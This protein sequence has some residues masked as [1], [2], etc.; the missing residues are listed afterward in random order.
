MTA[1]TPE[2]S[3]DNSVYILI[4]Q[5]LQN[6]FFLAE[7]GRLC[8]PPKMVAHMLIGGSEKDEEVADNVWPETEKNEEGIRR[9]VKESKL[10]EGPLYRFLNT[11]LNDKQRTNTLHIITIKDWHIASE[12]YDRERRTYGPHCEAG[13]WQAQVIDGFEKLLEPHGLN[14]VPSSVTLP[15][16]P[17]ALEDCRV[18]RNVYYE[19][20]SDTLFDFLPEPAKGN[21]S[22]QP[23]RLTRILDHIM[24]GGKKRAYVVVTGVYT[25][26][27]IQTL[28]TGL[29]SRYHLHN[30]IVS[31]VLTA[32]PTLERHLAGLDFAHK[33]L[34]VEIVHSL[35][36][37]I[38]VLHP[39]FEGKIDPE[40]TRLQPDFFKYK[41]YFL[42]K[43]YV[44]SYQDAKLSDYLDLTSHRSTAQYKLTMRVA[45]MLL[46]FGIIFLGIS[47]LA[48]ARYVIQPNQYSDEIIGVFGFTM[49]TNLVTIFFWRTLQNTQRSMLAQV[50]LRNY[51]ETYSTITGLVRHHFTAPEFL[52]DPMRVTEPDKV[53]RRIDRQIEIIG[54]AADAMSD[55]FRDLTFRDDAATES[56]D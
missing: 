23:S 27:K 4:T 5:C 3:G 38:R 43:Q 41:T 47:A 22:P 11:L 21:G 26:I 25:D 48:A 15:S 54:K 6:S 28:L 24:E 50:R 55:N 39:K 16:A 35:N 36:D 10:K 49:L 8:L 53:L 56:S 37:T 45:W 13:T 1:D 2:T 46:I 52:N 32:A 12:N 7:E 14:P 33:V 40:I 30:L 19:V 20:R 44:L 18:G 34:D 31:D 29:R 9:C 51:L 17:D 42:D